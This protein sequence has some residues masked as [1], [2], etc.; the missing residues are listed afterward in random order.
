MNTTM[1]D[2]SFI[3]TP[4]TAPAPSDIKMTD[5]MSSLTSDLPANKIEEDK[6]V[7]VLKGL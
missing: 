4:V 6:L 7:N 3:K 5:N 2:A 1:T